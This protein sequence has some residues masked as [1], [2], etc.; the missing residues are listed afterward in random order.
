MVKFNMGNV[1]ITRA[2]NDAIVN[3][4][5]L[6]KEVMTALRRYVRCDWGNL[7]NNDMVLNNNAVTSG[8]DRIVARYGTTEG[9]IY[10]ITEHDRSYTTL[11]FCE[12]Y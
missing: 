8:L 12:E 10:I 5:Q 2:L 1:V 7:C 11:L 9:D 3:N 4:G 6:A